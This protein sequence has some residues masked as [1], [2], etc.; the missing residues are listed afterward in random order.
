MSDGGLTGSARVLAILRC[1]GERP[2]GARLGDVAAAVDAP[3]SSVHRALAALVTSG[4]ARQDA[5]GV[6]HLGFDLLQ[7]VFGYQEA[8]QSS[9][10][11]EPVL[12]RLADATG[13]TTHYG[14]L[15][16]AD[17]VYQAKVSPTRKTF[18]MSSVIGGGNPAYRT[19]LG[20]ALLMHRLRDLGAVQDYVAQYGPLPAK[21][22]HTLTTAELLDAAFREGRERGFAMDLQENDLGIVC[23]AFPLFLDSPS[24]PAGALSISA[25][26]SRTSPE[27]LIAQADLVRGIVREELGE[28]VLAPEPVPADGGTTSE[29]WAQPQ[30]GAR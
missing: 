16:G 3:K 6:Y 25:V 28:R 20:K 14:V 5:D 13:E 26:S 9:L 22:A 1:L 12:R 4:F 30:R 8:Q 18:Q 29:P 17:I 24:I 10:T 2:A 27:E 21:T 11:V 19:G 15:V 23:I 7:L